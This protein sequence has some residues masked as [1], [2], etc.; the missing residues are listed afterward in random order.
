MTNYVFTGNFRNNQDAKGAYHAEIKIV[1]PS[2]YSG[3]DAMKLLRLSDPV[4]V[5]GK[6]FIGREMALH[7]E[8]TED[9][10]WHWHPRGANRVPLVIDPTN[11]TLRGVRKRRRFT[12]TAHGKKL[13]VYEHIGALAWTGLTG[14]VVRLACE[15]PPYD[16]MDSF[17]PYDGRV[18]GY[19]NSLKPYLQQSDERASW[20]YFN[21]CFKSGDQ[22]RYVHFMP[23]SSI[24][25]EPQLQVNITVDFPGIGYHSQQFEIKQSDLEQGFSAHTLGWPPWLY[26]IS[27]YLPKGIWSHHQHLNWKQ[28]VSNEVLLSRIVAHRFADILGTLSLVTKGV[29]FS[30]VID[31]YC[32][33][34]HH[35]VGLLYHLANQPC[36]Y[37]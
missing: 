10:G 32:G 12:L 36:T 37:H 26:Y 13:D 27:R 19:W 9:L 28:E 30:G 3:R 15:E 33:G 8:P 6:S 35:D 7:F 11:P 17:P 21:K 18:A 29:F 20:V 5:T 31:S 1:V 16:F 24:D 34:H 2:V 4:V 14:V 23:L 25:C 22:K